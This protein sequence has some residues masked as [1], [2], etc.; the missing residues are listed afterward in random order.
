VLH[1]LVEGDRREAPYQHTP[2]WFET[3]PARGW[4]SDGEIREWGATEV[5]RKRRGR[6][7][8]GMMKW[9]EEV[10]ASSGGGVFAGTRDM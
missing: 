10:A 1:A 4:G 5:R 7:E 3:P 9:E 6:R 8:E 2:S